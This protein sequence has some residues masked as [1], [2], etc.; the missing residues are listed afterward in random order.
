[1]TKKVAVIPGDGIGEEVMR[2]AVKV[3]QTIHDLHLVDLKTVKFEYGADQYLETGI[4]LPNEVI[5]EFQTKYDALLTGPF[6]DPRISNRKYLHAIL[7][8]LQASLGLSVYYCPIRLLHPDLYPLLE[9]F[10]DDLRFTIFSHNTEGGDIDAG[11]MSKSGTPDETALQQFFVT[12]AI[13]KRVSATA[14]KFAQTRK[15]KR[16][17]LAQRKNP[18]R[19]VHWLWRSIVEETAKTYPDIT[20][21]FTTAENLAYSLMK[22]PGNYDIILI[23]NLSRDIF[24]HLSAVLQG[25]LGL[26]SVGDLNPGEF[27]LFRPL[28]GSVPRFKGKNIANPFGAI[29][30]VQLLLEFF[31]KPKTGQLIEDAVA[32]CLDHRLT[33]PDL[34]GSLGTEEVGD[35]VC[36]TIE[37]LYDHIR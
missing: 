25:G 2:Q 34:N 24:S 28:H 8:R 1:M 7:P 26:V 32:Y 12:R 27:G 29:R 21:N 37:T 6:G 35:Y 14:F 36:Q 33:T 15:L 31:G 20:V 3:C 19:N 30:C 4:P 17:T 10:R 23:E 13:I 16:I 22:E 5:Q 11:G 9:G 18:F